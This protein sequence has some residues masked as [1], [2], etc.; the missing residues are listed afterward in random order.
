MVRCPLAPRRLFRLVSPSVPRR[1][2]HALLAAGAALLGFEQPVHGLYGHLKLG[3]A[4]LGR[5]EVFLEEVADGDGGA[6]LAEDEPGLG[7]EDELQ[8]GVAPPAYERVEEGCEDYVAQDVRPAA[9]VEAAAH[10]GVLERYLAVLLVGGDGLV[11]G[12][13]V[14]PDGGE[15]HD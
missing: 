7:D 6:G 15:L 14:A 12:P 4:G 9:G 3:A 1:H 2:P 13:V 10:L 8:D 11:L 5:R